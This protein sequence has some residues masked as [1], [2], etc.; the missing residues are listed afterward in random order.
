MSI[1]LMYVL[2]WHKALVK[3]SVTQTQ[4]PS[5]ETRIW[6]ESGLKVDEQRCRRTVNFL[7]SCCADL[8]PLWFDRMWQNKEGKCVATTEN[9]VSWDTTPCNLAHT[10]VRRC[11]ET[12]SYSIFKIESCSLK[13]V[14]VGYSETSS[15]IYQSTWQTHVRHIRRQYNSS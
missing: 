11:G 4:T 3:L 8:H 7:R 9:A 6:P 2:K 14:V 1:C 10:Y 12:L 15:F 13:I 5:T